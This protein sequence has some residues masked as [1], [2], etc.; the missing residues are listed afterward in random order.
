MSFTVDYPQHHTRKPWTHR[1]AKLLLVG[2]GGVVQPRHL[3]V[4]SI[5]E[6]R[7]ILMMLLDR[8][9]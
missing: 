9:L 5:Q 8:Q 7:R 6:D 4:H 1:F 3:P 2:S